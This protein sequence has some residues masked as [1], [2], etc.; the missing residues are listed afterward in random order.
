M[1]FAIQLNPLSLFCMPILPACFYDDGGGG[2][3]YA[4]RFEEIL[5]ILRC[6]LSPKR[7]STGNRTCSSPFLY[8]S[9]RQYSVDPVLVQPSR[10][11]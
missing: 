2:P 11:D 10:T 4:I 7:T 8:L 1:R 6:F 5:E 3:E 9:H